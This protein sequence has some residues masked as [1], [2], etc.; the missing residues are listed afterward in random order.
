MIPLEF[1]FLKFY[2]INIK[3]NCLAEI[4]TSG[5]FVFANKQGIRIGHTMK[6]PCYVVFMIFPNLFS[7]TM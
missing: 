4:K 7:T 5:S 6:K 1:Y 3:H 2:L